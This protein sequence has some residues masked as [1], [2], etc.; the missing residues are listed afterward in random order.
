ML[1][2]TLSSLASARGTINCSDSQGQITYQYYSANYGM[3][4]SPEMFQDSTQWNYQ[5]KMVKKITHTVG[6]TETVEGT[7]VTASFDTASEVQ[8]ALVDQ[9]ISSSRT[10]A[11]KVNF[12]LPQTSLISRFMV[13]DEYTPPPAP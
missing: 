4:P 10:Y 6:G 7:G 11:V 12:L 5:G 13:C 8:L 9:H 3:R 1:S 2:I